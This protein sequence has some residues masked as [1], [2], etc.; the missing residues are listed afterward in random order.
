MMKH[1][2]L[3]F[4][5]T[6]ALTWSPLAS[7]FMGVGETAEIIPQGQYRIGFA[8]QLYMGNGGGVDVGAYLDMNI[9]TSINSRFELGS[10]VTQ[11]WA[12]GSLKWVPFPDYERQPA[13][14]GRA[15]LMYV[16]DN[17]QNFFNTQITPIVS[18]KYDTKIGRMI[19]YAGLPFTFIYENSV[20][21]FVISKLCF[22]SEWEVK[23][24]FQTGAELSIDLYNGST[25]YGFTATSLTLFF[26]FQFDEKIGFKK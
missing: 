25:T 18:K 19:P 1:L 23:K 12:S 8:P 14:G 2:V 11:F 3:S 13:I 24:D 4:T 9:D 5:L 10:G 20:D 26:N 16:R 22:G 21:N 15:V 7:A 17:N 6:L